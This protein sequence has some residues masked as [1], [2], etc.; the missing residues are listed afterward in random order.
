MKTMLSLTLIV[1]GLLIAGCDYQLKSAR[2]LRLPQGSVIRGKEAFVALKCTDCHS[3]VGVPLPEP[4]VRPEAVVILGGEVTK[5]RTIGD[6]L[7]SIIHPA[8]SISDKIPAA[9]ARKDGKSPMRVANDV[10]TVTQMVD[11]VTFLQPR[12]VKISVP[13]EWIVLP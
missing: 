13:Q 8:Q 6:L 1:L 3:V 9:A 10:M 4:T 11:L 2:S 12:Y 5:V 7:T